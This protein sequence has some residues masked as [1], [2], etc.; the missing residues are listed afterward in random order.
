MVIKIENNTEPEILTA[1][2]TWCLLLLHICYF[3][4]RV[5][6]ESQTS[7]RTLQSQY[8]N[9]KNDVIVYICKSHYINNRFQ[10]AC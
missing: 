6:N 9:V 7:S 8:K 1:D 4:S 3:Y 5:A 10:L 2:T